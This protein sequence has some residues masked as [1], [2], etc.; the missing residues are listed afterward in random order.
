MQYVVNASLTFNERSD[1]ER[2]ESKLATAVFD[3]LVESWREVALVTWCCDSPSSE[4]VSEFPGL[5][6]LV[7]E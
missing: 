4:G 5:D 2:A 6:R 7:F 3:G 1:A